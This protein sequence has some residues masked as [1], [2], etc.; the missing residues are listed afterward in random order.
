MKLAACFVAVAVP[1][2]AAPITQTFTSY[3]DWF[4]AVTGPNIAVE[5]LSETQDFYGANSPAANAE[6]MQ[7]ADI[8]GDGY[9]N[10]AWN[11]SKS[12][13]GFAL[14]LNV[15]P[16]DVQLIGVSGGVAEISLPAATNSPDAFFFGFASSE[17]F[18]SVE[19]DTTP[20]SQPYRLAG[21]YL[22]PR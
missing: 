6:F 11:F 5:H 2:A 12:M 22:R 17:V 16:A 20:F 18:Q 8:E 15:D 1:L 14:D 4:A 19:I 13:T 9:W 7:G 21:Q 10:G 3:S